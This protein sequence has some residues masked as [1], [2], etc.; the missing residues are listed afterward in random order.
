[1]E[2][3]SRGDIGPALEATLRSIESEPDLRKVSERAGGP[4][5]AYGAGEGG[6]IATPRIAAVHEMVE[7][8]RRVVFVGYF[9]RH[10]V[11]TPTLREHVEALLVRARDLA[12]EQVEAELTGT[13]G[14]AP[15]EAA[16]RS[17]E[18]ARSFIGAL[19]MLRGMLALDVRAAFEGDPA[20]RSVDEVIL[21]YPGVDA[22]FSHRVA[23]ALF[24]L[25]APMVARI[26]AELAHSRTGI[27]IHPGTTIGRSFFID[28]G[29]GVVI[30]ETARIGD[31]VKIYQGVT[32][33]AK[34][35]PRDAS[36]EYVTGVQRHPTIGNRVT[37]YADAVILGGDTVIGDDCVITGNVFLTQ[38]V[39]P[40][41]V[42]RAKQP[43]LA[44]RENK[45][46]GR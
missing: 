25:G 40:G 38:S 11:R 15:K 22:V 43:E 35:F 20:A 24:L 17:R 14:M 33:G 37:I 10:G 16:A 12:R 21:C 34:S 6:G 27:D 41:H 1:M 4:G 45:E 44:L 7:H 23:H 28:H 39:P 8:V 5:A 26:V 3:W 31:D 18:I 19:P 2:S 13:A 29:T 32:I 42:V 9:E 30:G 46:K 36:G